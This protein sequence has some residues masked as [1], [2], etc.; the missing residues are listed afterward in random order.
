M[1]PQN[2][3]TLIRGA[4]RFGEPMRALIAGGREP[5]LDVFEIAEALGADVLD[6]LDVDKSTLRTVTAMNR[7]GASVALAYLGYLQRE[8]YDAILT[9]GEDIRLPLAALLQL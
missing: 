3:R 6:Y 1:V 4:G 9:T 2:M 7:A 8:N 5:R